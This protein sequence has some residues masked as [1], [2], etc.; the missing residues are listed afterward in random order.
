MPLTTIDHYSP[1][2]AHTA[3][4]KRKKENQSRNEYTNSDWMVPKTSKEEKG[5]IVRVCVR[6]RE[7]KDKR[8][9]I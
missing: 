6:C 7:K 3:T 1:P 9:K 4:T 8:E 5:R 2:H